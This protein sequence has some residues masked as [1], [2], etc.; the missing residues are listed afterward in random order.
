LRCLLRQSLDPYS[1]DWRDLLNQ[2]SKEKDPKRL[3]QLVEELNR[4]IQRHDAERKNPF[5]RQS[6]RT[7]IS[8]LLC[9]AVAATGADSGTAQLF[10]TS[11]NSLQLVAQRGFEKEFVDHFKQVHLEDGCACSAVLS[12]RCRIVVENVETDFLFSDTA[13]DVVLRARV[14]SVASTPLVDFS[15]KLVGVVSTHF[16]H[17]QI[18][19][20]HIW[21]RVDDLVTTFIAESQ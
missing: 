15:G 1:S 10:D 8:N 12:G 14:R 9:A 20:R 18:P 5:L 21:D 16:R 19:S 4:H 3:I 13:R 17:P 11:Q 6:Y 2:T 7:R